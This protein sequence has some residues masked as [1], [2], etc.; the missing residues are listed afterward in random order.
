MRCRTSLLAH[1][2]GSHPQISGHSEMHQGYSNFL[3]LLKLRCKVSM[4]NSHTLKGRY[5]LDKVLDGYALSRRILAAPSTKPIFLLREPESSLKSIVAMGRSY[6]GVGWHGDPREALAYYVARLAQLEDIAKA[7]ADAGASP[8]FFCD[9]EDLLGRTDLVLRELARWLGLEIELS[10]N[11]SV[12]D[13]TGRLG[14]G[15]PSDAIKSARVINSASCHG[16]IELDPGILEEATP[17]Y[18]RCR[19]TLLALCRTARIES[20]QDPGAAKAPSAP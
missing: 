9:S 4:D 15:D 3:D 11:Y 8:A 7:R 17:R 1:I 5:V 13:T 6:A 16:G 19:N 10:P 20:Q 2:L 14:W 18:H 12:F